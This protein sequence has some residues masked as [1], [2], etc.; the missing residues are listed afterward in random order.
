MTSTISFIRIGRLLLTVLIC[1]VLLSGCYTTSIIPKNVAQ[2]HSP[3]KRTSW[4]FFWGL[5]E[6]KK[7]KNTDA[8]DCQGNGVSSVVVKNN[9]GYILLS[10]V[11]LGIVV[12]VGIEY[13][14]AK[15]GQVPPP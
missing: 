3:H 5:M 15:D 13:D 14:C 12:P 7:W 4:S 9:L 8:V 2:V 6:D 1:T 10:F 11:T